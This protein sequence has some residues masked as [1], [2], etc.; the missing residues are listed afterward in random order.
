LRL[1]GL[2]WAERSLPQSGADI[3]NSPSN[4]ENIA[5]ITASSNASSI[6]F[7]PLSKRIHESGCHVIEARL[8]TLGQTV[9][10]SIL[11]NGT[12]DAI[13]KLEMAI[14]R[15]ERKEDEQIHMQRTAGRQAQGDRLPYMIE[16]VSADRPGILF[17]LTEFLV[18]RGIQIEQLSSTR[19]R[20]MQTDTEAVTAQLQIGVPIKMHIA[21]LRDEFMEFCDA[22]NLDAVLDPVKF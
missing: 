3:V 4:N 17:A 6:L 9:V 19:Y 15:L 7:L 5:L 14:D 12:W 1:L 10:L 18:A 22:E 16:V 21:S 20:T 11:V 8:A 2:L 13:A